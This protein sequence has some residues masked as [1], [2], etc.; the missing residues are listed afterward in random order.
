MPV[1]PWPAEK[2]PSPQ[3]TLLLNLQQ[4]KRQSFE[5]PISKLGLSGSLA[6]SASPWSGSMG[7]AAAGAAGAAATG[8][9]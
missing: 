1:Y 6:L 7:T 2:D 3:L 9:Y 8:K 4:G 5:L